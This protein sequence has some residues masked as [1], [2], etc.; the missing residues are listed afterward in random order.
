MSLQS[1]AAK[2]ERLAA[3]LSL[4]AGIVLL[5]IKFAA[6]I[7]TGSSAVLSDAL[8]SIVNVLAAAFALYAVILRIIRPTRI[9]PMGTAR[10]NSCRRDSKGG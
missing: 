10:S 1:D 7:L 8:E 6:Y 9:T 2:A 3:A 4:G 5:G